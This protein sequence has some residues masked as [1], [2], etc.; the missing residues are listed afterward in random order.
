MKKLMYVAVAL[1]MAM[2]GCSIYSA[3][4]APTPLVLDNVK[5]G[6]SRVTVV[7][8]LG[9]PKTSETKGDSKIDVHEFVNG[10][11]GATKARIMLYIAGD[12]FTAGLSEL[13]FWPLELAVGQGTAGRAIVTYGTDDIAKSVLLARADGSPWDSESSTIEEK[14]APALSKAVEKVTPETGANVR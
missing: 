8:T 6:A 1:V 4:T 13:V 11:P 5:I 7:G 2:P 12:L 14:P 10:S 3:A 9:V